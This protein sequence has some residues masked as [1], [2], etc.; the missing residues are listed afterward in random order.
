MLH[1]RA[2]TL[3]YIAA[4]APARHIHHNMRP[5]SCAYRHL[6]AQNARAEGRE[7]LAL[8][9]VVVHA[10]HDVA[11][12]QHT[13][14]NAQR[15]SVRMACVRAA[16]ALVRARA[17]TNE[18]CACTHASRPGR[19]NRPDPAPWHARAP[20]VGR[21]ALDNGLDKNLVCVGV[22][23]EKNSDA[24]QAGCR[25]HTAHVAVGHGL[26]R[27]KV[28]AA[29]GGQRVEAGEKRDRG[30]CQR[31][32]EAGGRHGRDIGWQ[33]GQPCPTSAPAR[34]SPREPAHPRTSPTPGRRVGR[35]QLSA[36]SRS[37]HPRTEPMTEH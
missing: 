12:P 5:R 4:D 23:L 16:R 17:P 11:H 28:G 35:L 6:R 8:N 2:H 10:H 3:T 26:G 20:A 9:V 37:N 7:G 27:R 31:D 14:V 32:G 24:C 36:S 13:A 25:H 18:A 33:P 1:V 19:R 34:R 21:A 29:A 22:L 30:A 15:R